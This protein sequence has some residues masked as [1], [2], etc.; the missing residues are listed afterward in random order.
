MLMDKL[1][2]IS[3]SQIPEYR[4]LTEQ[5]KLFLFPYDAHKVL[6]KITDITEEDRYDAVNY[7]VL[8]FDVVAIEDTASCVILTPVKK[9]IHGILQSWKWIE[10]LD[11]KKKNSKAFYDATPD[12]E[13][14]YLSSMFP[15][16]AYEI[17]DGII[18]PLT[19]T[20]KGYTL[21][22]TVGSILIGN[23]NELLDGRNLTKKFGVNLP[24]D[25]ISK[26]FGKNAMTAIEELM[27]LNNKDRFIL[28]RIP[29]KPKISG[30]QIPRSHQRSNYTILTVGEIRETFDKDPIAREAQR[31]MV[32]GH[33]RRRHYRSLRNERYTR[34]DEGKIKRIL[35]EPMWCGPQEAS[36][37]QHKYLVRLDL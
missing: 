14:D 15:D 17:C 12:P 6:P 29:H 11:L 21:E 16:D 10:I 32:A 27:M 33:V 8:P 35:I 30:K 5:A 20:E 23:K 22:S 1:C 34:D 24:M 2:G 26:K 19:F 7:F 31:T 4:E 18:T 25:K 37:G 13:L 36:I 3:E 9:G 28:E